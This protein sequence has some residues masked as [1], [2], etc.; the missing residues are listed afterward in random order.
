M[1]LVEKEY[2]MAII[3]IEYGKELLKDYSPESRFQEIQEMEMVLQN[4]S[5]G[6]EYALLEL[7][8]SPGY[9]E[10]EQLHF[11]I[12]EYKHAYFQARQFLVEHHPGRLASLEEELVEQKSQVFQS[13]HA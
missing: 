2:W 11:R 5:Y 9:L 13:Y 4:S 3:D 7:Q 8:E 1:A 6:H 12:E 10:Q